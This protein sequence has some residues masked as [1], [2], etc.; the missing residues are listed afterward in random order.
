[1]SLLPA[2]VKSGGVAPF[3]PYLIN[4][5]VRLNDDDSAH[6]TRTPLIV[7]S[8]QTFTGLWRI[9]RGNIDTQQVI[10]QADINGS[11]NTDAIRFDADGRLTI[12]FNDT[13]SGYLRTSKLFRDPNAFYEIH[14]KVNTALA[15][16]SDRVVITVNGERITEFVT[17]AYPSL[18]HVT[19]FNSTE[20]HSI[21]RN[22]TTLSQYAD[23]YLATVIWLDGLYVDASSFSEFK[24]GVRIPKKYTGSYG[25]NGFHLDFADSGNIG[26]DVSGNGNHWTPNNLIASDVVLDS[27]TNN[28]CTLNPLAKDSGSVYSQGNLRDGPSSVNQGY[29]QTRANFAMRT[30][31][32]YAEVY[33]ENVTLQVLTIG[34]LTGQDGSGNPIDRYA[35]NAPGT[36]RETNTDSAYGDSFT[37]GDI[38]G[39]LYD[40]DAGSITYYKNGVS[41]GVATTGLDTSLDWFFYT[42][43]LGPG[44]SVARWNFGQDSTF[45]GATTAGGNTDANGIGDFK[46][47]VP[48]G[49]LALCSSNL[50]EPVIGPNS[51]T[52]AEDHFN[53]VLY[54]GT[55][56]TNAVTG[57][58]FQPD[59][60]GLKN[61]NYGAGTNHVLVDAIRGVI[62]GL[63]SNL[64]NAEFSTAGNLNSIDVDGFTVD[65]TTHDYN[66]LND[67]F[68]AWNWKMGGASGVVNNNGSI[69][70]T[71]SANVDAGQSVGIYQSDG[72]DTNQTVG[73]GLVQPPERVV[74]KSRDELSRHWLIWHKDMPNASYASLY[75]TAVPAAN[76]FG[77]NAPTATVFGVYGGQGNRGTS[78]LV[79]QAYHS[80]EGYS[81]VGSYEGNGNTDGTFVY[82]GF[83]PAYIE[84]DN[85]DGVENFRVYDGEREGFNPNND[86]LYPNLPNAED[87]ATTHIEFLSNG[88][89]LRSTINNTSGN[90]YAYY[91]VAETPFKYANAR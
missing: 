32:W 2:P 11:S 40:A 27:P 55:D 88:F 58:G 13:N 78:N 84:I 28:W 16:A 39:V 71:V 23:Y 18:N 35:Y 51:A 74:V 10:F 46:Y 62:N 22:N 24:N 9:K 56:T 21:G 73:H 37:T 75:T 66:F 49:A 91:A 69:Q 67:S 65:G 26:N 29:P 31:K 20:V 48:T 43:T 1:M 72:T 17:E 52:V 15:T 76:R 50:P 12:Y 82:L 33:A 79:F 5:S 4:Q 19:S 83:R 80:V 70:S 85:I 64:T 36:K 6:L 53:T 87:P 45:A 30:G 25:T 86:P 38:L 8:R 7:G 68:V 90:T 54:T 34:I 41:Q 63:A 42:Q 81:A 89:K 47:P 3:Y 77:P 61:R 60:L 57:V 59:V 44:Q 14:V